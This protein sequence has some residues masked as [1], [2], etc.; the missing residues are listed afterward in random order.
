MYSLYIYLFNFFFFRGWGATESLNQ[1]VLYRKSV[2]P[3]SNPFPFYTPFLTEKAP[4]SFTKILLPL[5]NGTPFTYLVKNVESLLTAVSA[6]SL[7]DEKI[8]K[9]GN[10]FD[11]VTAINFSISRFRCFYRQKWQF[12]VPFLWTSTSKIPTLSYTWSLKKIPLWVEPPSTGH[13][14]EH[15]PLPPSPLPRTPEN[16]ATE[17]E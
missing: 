3:R 16:K 17:G 12:S 14:R 10:F 13:Y 11:F 5:T 9:P 6:L 4:L 8:T 2:A 1:K 15:L 7:K